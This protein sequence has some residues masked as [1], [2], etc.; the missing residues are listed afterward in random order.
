M[1][2]PIITGKRADTAVDIIQTY[3]SL[4]TYISII[5]SV[6]IRLCFGQN[7]ITLLPDKALGSDDASESRRQILHHGQDRTSKG[8]CF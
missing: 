6:Q 4:L 1:F 5:L 7:T 2:P 3:W 8:E